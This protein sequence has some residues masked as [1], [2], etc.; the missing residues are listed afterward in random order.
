MFFFIIRRTIG[1]EKNKNQI[2]FEI[3]INDF[4]FSLVF[5]IIY[6]LNKIDCICNSLC[7]F[8]RGQILIF[9]LHQIS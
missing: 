6:L 4:L 8:C 5:N 3:F 2:S 9:E 1:E 7:S